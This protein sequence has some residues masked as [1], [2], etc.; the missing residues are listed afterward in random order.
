MSIHTLIS[1]TPRPTPSH[2]ATRRRVAQQRMSPCSA[3]LSSAHL[4]HRAAVARWALANGRS[5]NLT[6]LTLLIGT[7]Q[8]D[9]S[10]SK[11]PFTCWTDRSLDDFL[12]EHVPI[13]A[14]QHSVHVPPSFAETLFVYIDALA[15]TGGLHPKSSYR[16]TRDG[17]APGQPHGRWN[18]RPANR[19]SSPAPVAGWRSRQAIQQNLTQRQIRATMWPVADR[20][21]RGPDDQIR[22]R[23]GPPSRFGFSPAST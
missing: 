17:R 19:R 18:E 16:P 11:V 20:S 1:P 3:A 7:K 23:R 8:A 15:H 10:V 13:W 9:A 22:P 12:Y 6:A 5:I 21:V 14:M 4:A 2:P